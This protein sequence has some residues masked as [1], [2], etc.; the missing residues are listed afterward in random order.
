MKNKKAYDNLVYSVL[1]TALIVMLVLFANACNREVDNA[2][3][4]MGAKN[5]THATQVYEIEFD[6]AKYIV[7]QTYKGVGVTKK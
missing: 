1:G 7:V 2:T 6:G 3:P 4:K 5:I